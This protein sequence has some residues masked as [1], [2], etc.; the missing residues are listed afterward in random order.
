V[1]GDEWTEGLLL[2]ILPGKLST[3]GGGRRQRV[4]HAEGYG[5]LLDSAGGQHLLVESRSDFVRVK[6][7]LRQT[8]KRA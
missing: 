3:G 5:Y 2:G 4:R 7:I 8:K 6:S 1:G